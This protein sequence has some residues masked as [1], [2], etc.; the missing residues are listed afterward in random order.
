MRE[1]FLWVEKYR[2]TKISECIL[3]KSLQNIFQGIVDSGVLP[4]LLLSGNP[5]CG[6]TTIAK[7]ICNELDAD[8]LFLNGSEERRLDVV[9]TTVK[10]FSMGI[11]VTGKRKVII[12]DE[13]DYLALDTQ[14]ALRYII[15]ESA[16]NCSFIFTCNNK[17]KIIPALQSRCSSID[18]KFSAEEKQEIFQK[19][20]VRLT[21]ILKKESVEFDSKVVAHL[22]KKYFPDF[23]K[24]INELQKFASTNA[25]KIDEGVLADIQDPDLKNLIDAMKEQSF[26]KIRS[27]VANNSD[28]QSYTNLYDVLS[29]KLAP[30]SIPNAIAIL[31]DHQYKHAFSADPQIP[32]LNCILTIV[33]NCKF[34]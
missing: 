25:N 9:R 24:V 30:T 34:L 26:S 10:Q 14:P 2:P 7:A 12:Y 4:N 17:N 21:E 15:E 8:F 19:E 28:V 13:A 22:L 1:H 29:T 6:K 20:Y 33:S 31:A 32:L 16:K 18:F 27:W 5:G 23:R 11:S 3:P